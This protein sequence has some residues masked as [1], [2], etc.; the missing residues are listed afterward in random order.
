MTY[1]DGT[2]FKSNLKIKWCRYHLQNKQELTN[3]N[4]TEKNYRI[5]ILRI[6]DHT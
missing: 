5:Y 3:E 1:K 4:F 2:A 6:N